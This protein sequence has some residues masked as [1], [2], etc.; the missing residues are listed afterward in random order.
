LEFRPDDAIR[1]AAR[2]DEVLRNDPMHT[3]NLSDDTE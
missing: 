3:R 1:A 2:I